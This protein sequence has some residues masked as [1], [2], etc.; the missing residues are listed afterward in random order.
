MIVSNATSF[1]FLYGLSSYLCPLIRR[2]F[3]Q[4]FSIAIDLVPLEVL[5]RRTTFIKIFWVRKR[6]WIRVL[7]SSL[8]RIIFWFIVILASLQVFISSR[9]NFNNFP[10]SWKITINWRGEVWRR[11]RLHSFIRSPGSYSHICCPF[12]FSCRVRGNKF[13]PWIYL[14]FLQIFISQSRN[15][16]F[17]CS[18]ILNY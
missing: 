4:I 10:N 1:R 18:S 3:S 14:R 13:L 8:N 17:Y 15:L 11:L 9:L 12:S 5:S 16:W 7:V 2:D 6:T